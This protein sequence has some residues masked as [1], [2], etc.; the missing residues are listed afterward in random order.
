M[1][2]SRKIPF[3]TFDIDTVTNLIQQRRSIFPVDF[4]G[5][6]IPKAQVEQILANAHWAPTHGRTEP[7]FFVVFT[8]SALEKFGQDHGEMYK[9]HTP[10]EE[11]V[12]A[13]YN[14]LV[15]RPTECSHMI[16]ICMKRGDNP[17]IPVIEETNAVACAVQNMYLTTFALGLAGYWSSGGMTYH[18]AMKDY[19]NLGPNDQCLGFFML[20]VPKDK[21]QYPRG[22]RKVKWEEKV[23]WRGWLDTN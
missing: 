16:A 14:K 8:G 21:E 5:E 17:K 7:W 13:K 19:L 6:I 22:T 12:E 10:P 9:A 1:I 18:P 23:E 20:G 2:Q 3:P 4:S 11:F 15:R